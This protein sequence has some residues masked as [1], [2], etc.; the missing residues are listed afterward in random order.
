MSVVVLKE[1]YRAHSSFSC[2]Q[3]VCHIFL[4][5]LNVEVKN[6][7]LNLK[8][9][10]YWLGTTSIYWCTTINKHTV[11]FSFVL[12]TLI[13]I[14]ITM[15]S[16][17]IPDWTSA[18]VYLTLF[19]LSKHIVYIFIAIWR[20]VNIFQRN[21]IYKNWKK[22]FTLKEAK[23]S[24]FKENTPTLIRTPSQPRGTVYSPPSLTMSY[25]LKYVDN[26]E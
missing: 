18:F 7:V 16:Q 22:C 2:K 14:N 4:Y 21:S 25:P 1:R 26:Y 19:E 11:L 20:V 12:F 13:N 3:S 6:P 9:L 23:R 10:W 17:T 24:N 8:W 5:V 15:W